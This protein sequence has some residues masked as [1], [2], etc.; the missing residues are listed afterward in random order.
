MIIVTG[1]YGEA[2]ALNYYGRRLGLPPAVSQHNSFFLWGPGPGTGRLVIAVGM[3]VEGLAAGFESVT[4]AARLTSPY[5]MPYETADPILVCRGL[6]RPLE[7]AW[8]SG[9]HFI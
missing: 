5:A 9:K 8:R 2:G 3:S 7:E 1:N 4:E 6:K